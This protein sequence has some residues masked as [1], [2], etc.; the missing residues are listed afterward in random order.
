MKH[1]IMKHL[2]MKHLLK[3]LI[4]CCVL[5]GFTSSASA[6]EMRPAF[7]QLNE[8]EAGKFEVIW[9]QPVLDDRRLPLDPALPEGCEVQNAKAPERTPTALLQ[10]WQ[11]QCDLSVGTLSIA[12]LTKTLTDVMVR[13]KYVNGD[14]IQRILRPDE[15]SMDLAEDTPYLWSYLVIGVEHLLGGIDHIL[16]VIG[17]VL[18]IKGVG[19]LVKTIT[20]FTIAHSITLALSVTGL[21]Y[22][23]Q[24]PV[25]AVIA[26]SIVFLA[27]ELLLPEAQRSPLTQHRPWLMAFGFGLLHGFGFA[28]ALSDIGL[29]QEQLTLALL[30]FNI[31]LELGQLLVVAAVLLLAWAIGP[32]LV[33]LT[34]AGKTLDTSLDPNL[35]K[36][37]FVNAQANIGLLNFPLALAMGALASYWTIDRVLALLG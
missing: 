23:P 9:K 19:P 13:I 16:F 32:L 11:T 7:L 14:V 37:A 24:A 17:L 1:L 26:L 3:Q 18:Y 31:G 34:D 22:V 4:C 28:G 35:G 33:Q 10:T 25:E 20:S 36:P 12:G 2:I 30:L 8:L 29:P 21:A 15:P 27:R 5:L 6:H